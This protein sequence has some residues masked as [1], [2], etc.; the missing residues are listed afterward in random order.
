LVVD[1]QVVPLDDGSSVDGGGLG[2]AGVEAAVD[3]LEFVV[4]V[5]RVGEGPFLL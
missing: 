3:V 2:D 1:V 4:A 5:A